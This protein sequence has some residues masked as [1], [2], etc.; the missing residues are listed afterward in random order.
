IISGFVSNKIGRKKTLLIAAILFFISALLSAYP[1]FLFFE[2]GE[3]TIA[4]FIMFNIYRII[5][6]VG[7]GFASGLGP[8]YISE[9]APAKIRG[10]LVTLN[11]LA[12]IFGTLVVYFVNYNIA[13]GQ[14]ISWMNDI[15]WRYM[16][17]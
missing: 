2:K 12:I 14:S 8:L 5:G 15:G 11:N 13:V 3:P 16:F 9:T 17:A 6:G 4:L 10:R 1:E 7:V